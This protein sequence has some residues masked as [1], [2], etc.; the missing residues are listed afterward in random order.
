MADFSQPKQSENNQ[1]PSSKRELSSD[2]DV[3][4]SETDEDLWE[5]MQ[6]RLPSKLNEGEDTNDDQCEEKDYNELI[7]AE[8]NDTNDDQSDKDSDE[9]SNSN[10]S[11][12]DG[13]DKSELVFMLSRII[14]VKKDGD[15]GG[16]DCN[17]D[18][19]RGDENIYAKPDLVEKLNDDA[20][21]EVYEKYDAK[22]SSSKLNEGE[23]SKEKIPS[24]GD[25]S[26]KKDYN[27]LINAEENDADDD[28]SDKDSGAESKSSSSKDGIQKEYGVGVVYP[29]IKPFPSALRE[30]V[31]STYHGMPHEPSHADDGASE[32]YFMYG[33]SNEHVALFKPRDGEA[34][35]SV[36][37]GGGIRKGT[38]TGEGYIREAAAYLLDH[39]GTGERG[40]SRDCPIGFRGVPP[41]C[42][43]NIW[44]PM[45]VDHVS[46]I[47]SVQKFISNEGNCEVRDVIINHFS[48]DEVH[49]I[50]M[51]DIR[52]ANA[53]RHLGNILRDS[54]QDGP[55]QLIPIDHGCCFPSS[56]EGCRFEWMSWPQATKPFS[57]ME[58]AYIETLSAEE[59][60]SILS[61]C[62][63]NMPSANRRIFRAA[64][65]LLK[66]GA[67]KGW[68]PFKIGE[69][70]SRSSRSS[71][72]ESCVR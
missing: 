60:I 66:R 51:L 65:M 64:T 28:Q 45:C 43:V 5:P 49:K 17:K 23:D 21:W 6:W 41:T 31:I 52:F 10:G 57:Q 35:G 33:A 46:G 22:G 48:V 20:L 55:C 67:K 40:A 59:D 16:N 38:I 47:G 7:D 61:T 34:K 24:G 30:L 3:D 4:S 11:R 68:S 58:C 32:T 2:K 37:P 9:E 18:S 62:G 19:N 54:R 63:W 14:C 25:Q 15:H 50:A 71:D 8:E 42:V 29:N 39:P 13:L 56:F 1:P 27:K 72:H 44:G 36:V 70:M 12:D 69:M 26:D 53:D